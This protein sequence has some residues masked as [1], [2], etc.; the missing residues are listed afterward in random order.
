M[1]SKDS[2]S[3]GY[4]WPYQDSRVVLPPEGAENPF[5]KQ[6]QPNAIPELHDIPIGLVNRVIYR[7]KSRWHLFADVAGA[8]PNLQARMAHAPRS[9]GESNFC[10]R[11][12]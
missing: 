1:T 10:G 5:I 7:P 8:A 3:Y 2:L 12:M 9:G 4:H 11:P 6:A